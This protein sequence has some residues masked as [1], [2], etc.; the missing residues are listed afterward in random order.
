MT[1]K[2]RNHPTILRGLVVL[3]KVVQ[4]R[5]PT[6]ASELMEELDLPKPTL[7][8]ILQQLE[9]EGLLQREPIHRRFVPG[10][11][12][13][14]L[15]Q[16]V[17]SNRALGAPRHA[18]LRALSEEIGETCNC[19]MLDGDRTVYFD[20][21]EANWPHRI[22]LPVGS[23]LPLHCTASGKLFLAHMNTRQRRRLV[24]A[25]PLTRHTDRT[26]TDV[27]LLMAELKR[28]ENDGVGVDNEEYLA[29][30]VAV[31][32]PVFNPANE[33]CFTVSVH[34]PT[35]RKPLD[36]LRQYAPALRKAAAAMATTY[37]SAGNDDT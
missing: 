6:S 32:V 13:Q 22:Q 24:S 17:M 9:E 14:Q 16:G 8:R 21:V 18:I 23:K 15:A 12:T 28:I 31:S 36:A 4:A 3:E 11:R 19:T 35:I 29:G 34:A 37:C 33:I 7:N 20:R 27:E 5:R 1:T 25:A 2:K 10:P 26:I 30:M